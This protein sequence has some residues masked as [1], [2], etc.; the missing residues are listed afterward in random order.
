MCFAS[1]LS[2]LLDLG[3]H[4]SMDLLKLRVG[5]EDNHMCADVLLRCIV[6]CP[7]HYPAGRRSMRPLARPFRLWAGHESGQNTMQ[8]PLW[9]D[10]T[11]KC[12]HLTQHV[13]KETASRGIILAWIGYSRS[14]S[15]CRSASV[16]QLARWLVRQ[17]LYRRAGWRAGL[18]R[19]RTY[20]GCGMLGKPSHLQAIDN[21][22]DKNNSRTKGDRMD[23]LITLRQFRIYKG[24]GSPTHW[25]FAMDVCN[26][27]CT[28]CLQCL[29]RT[30]GVQS[31][32]IVIRSHDPLCRWYQQALRAPGHVRYKPVTITRATHKNPFSNRPQQRL[33]S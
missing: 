7:Q 13:Y 20:T 31:S 2:P 11:L 24:R 9:T 8:R 30:K 29:P 26:V 6:A 21:R 19:R 10:W 22:E 16:P 14:T 15:W 28:G 4:C 27:G 12:P 3:M 25:M 17:E 18:S 23:Y 1:L 5:E 32:Y 33:N